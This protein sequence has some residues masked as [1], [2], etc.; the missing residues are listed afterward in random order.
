M[1]QDQDRDR[2]RDQDQEAKKL[3]FADGK[4]KV[5]FVLVYSYRRRASSRA[6]L[7][8]HRLSVISNGNFPR[9]G[10]GAKGSS[11]EGGK[12]NQEEVVVD[13]DPA[14]P[15]EGEKWMVREEFETS[16]IE[17]GLEIERDKD[18]G[19][20]C[21]SVAMSVMACMYVYVICVFLQV[22]S[23]NVMA[24]LLTCMVLFRLKSS[25]AHKL[26]LY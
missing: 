17:A 18:V 10:A 11:E 4:R 13:M 14:D 20:R 9:G 2:E 16:L 26:T 1:D 24:C 19:V 5:D 3:Y 25:E 22:Y 21:K 8:Q 6:S 15:A 23:V 7:G 12:A